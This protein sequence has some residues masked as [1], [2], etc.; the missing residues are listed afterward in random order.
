MAFDVLKHNSFVKA[1]NYDKP[2]IGLSR[3]G[4]INR[5]IDNEYVWKKEQFIPINRSLEAVALIRSKGYRVV[6]LTN[7]GGIDT[8]KYTMSDVDRLHN[9]M[10]ELLGK[11]GCPSID[12]LYYSAS[13]DKKDPYVKPN[14]GMFKR[15]EE[16]IPFIKFNEGWYVGDTMAD[17]KAAI[18][19]G[20]KPILVRTGDGLETEN[21]LN[22]FTYKDIKK[23]VK[24]FD[25]LFQFASSL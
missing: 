13:L 9:Y 8:K 14:T 11:A 20:A 12:G 15:C 2:V 23:E 16:E 3:D 17:L 18:K 21:S 24:V 6:I 5:K 25:D 4:V 22:K 1:V 7:Q 10:L 19:I